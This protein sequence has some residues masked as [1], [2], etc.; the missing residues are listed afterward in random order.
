MQHHVGVEVHAWERLRRRVPCPQRGG[1]G[2]R[3][4]FDHPDRMARRPGQRRSVVG[5]AVADDDDVQ[6]AWRDSGEQSVQ[7]AP[8][9]RG[10]IVAQG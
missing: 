6:L 9:A 5:A 7:A 4:E 1:L 8:D 10:L 2:G 3:L